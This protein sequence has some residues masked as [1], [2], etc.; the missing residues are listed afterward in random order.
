[1][2]KKNSKILKSYKLKT[3]RGFTMIEMLVS[4][5]IF[6]LITGIVL[7]RHSQFSGNILIGNLAYDVA[8]SVRQAQVFGLSVREFE[9]G[10]GQFAIGYGVHFDSNTPS[11][12]IFFADVNDNQIYDGPSEVV[13]ILTLRN[14]YT[15]AEVC[16]ELPTGTKKC[17]PSDI[18]FLDIVFERP[19]PEAII[20]T[21]V[22]S[23]VYSKAEITVMS[24]KGA[25]RMV[26]VWSTGQISVEQGG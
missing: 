1:M 2:L 7:T 8:L 10:S 21:S 18:T 17:T 23:D 24:P 25:E 11:S 12:Y 6:A 20:N 5:A 14:G 9:V 3:N 26:T 15:I 13:E 16:G 22:L 4:L 19:N